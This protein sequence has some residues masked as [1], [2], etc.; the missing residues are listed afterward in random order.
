M[1]TENS[2]KKRPTSHR[3]IKSFVLRQ[4][5]LTSAQQNAL[6]NHWK[7]Y[8]IDFSEQLLDYG[9]LFDNKNENVVEIGFGNGES[10]L[11]QAINQPQYNFIGI[12][13]HGPGVGHLIHNANAQDIH[14]IKV[15]RH[16]AI[17]VLTRQIADNSIIQLQLFFPDPWHKKRHHKRRIL[18]PAFIE[19]AQQKLK[20]GGFFHMATDWQHYAKQMLEEMDESEA[21]RNISGNGNYSITKGARCETK[22][23][24]RGVRLGHGVW[25]LIYEKR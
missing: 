5:R 16:D 13:V 22:F 6:D 9:E 20:A 3:A 25:D 14:N 23:E 19:L 8:G 18:K 17:D 4:G 10:L 1:S 12:E 21:F 7:D 24:R 2:K 11:Q 15:I